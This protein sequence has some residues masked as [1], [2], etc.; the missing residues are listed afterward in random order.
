MFIAYAHAQGLHRS[1]GLEDDGWQIVSHLVTS[2]ADVVVVALT[3]LVTVVASPTLHCHVI[4]D[5]ADVG[6]PALQLNRCPA[7]SQ[8]NLRKSISHRALC[9]APC[10]DVALSKLSTT[11][12]SPALDSTV[13]KQSA[14]EFLTRAHT[15][16][17]ATGSQTDGR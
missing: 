7:S 4:Q 2:I 3:T 10:R 17:R 13:V 12:P 5:G 15:G 8:V 16:C 6:V 11:I 14:G 1:P 9:G